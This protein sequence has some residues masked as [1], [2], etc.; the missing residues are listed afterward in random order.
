MADDEPQIGSAHQDR[1]EAWAAGR[2]ALEV[3]G[4]LAEHQDYDSVWWRCD[5]QFAP[6]TFFVNCNDFFH[7][8][9]ADTETITPDNLPR[10]R[11]AF[12]DAKATGDHGEIYGPLLFAARER[13]LRPVM[14]LLSS[15][16][17]ALQALFDA[18]GPERT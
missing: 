14:P 18:C 1:E 8:A 5:G 9:C 10:L 7:Y 15:G 4:L 6:V 11:A 16:T 2:F 3:L 13:G 12:D 17:A